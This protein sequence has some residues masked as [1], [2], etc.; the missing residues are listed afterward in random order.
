MLS[1][2]WSLPCSL[3]R[4]TAQDV[5]HLA[6]GRFL[7]LV[8]YKQKAVVESRSGEGSFRDLCIVQSKQC[9]EKSRSGDLTSM[10]PGF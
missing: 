9:S 3:P 2:P 7:A 8:K 1:F 10:D 4:T 6:S 5:L